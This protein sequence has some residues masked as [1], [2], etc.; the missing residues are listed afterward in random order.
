MFMLWATL[1]TNTDGRCAQALPETSGDLENRP[2]PPS[3]EPR[4]RIRL[5]SEPLDATLIFGQE[6]QQLLCFD[7]KDSRVYLRSGPLRVRHAEDG[8][9][10][11][12]GEMRSNSL[13]GTGVLSI[14]TLVD[15][16]SVIRFQG[17]SL[18][19]FVDLVPFTSSNSSAKSA[20]VDVI[21][22]VFLE[23]YLPGVLDVE[24]YGHWPL[25]TFQAQAVAARSY[26]LAEAAFWK[27]RRHFD[28][29]AGPESQ[30]WS[31]NGGSSKAR[32]AVQETFGMVLLHQG[33]IVPAYYSAACGGFPASADNA[34]SSR[35]SHRIGPLVP[36]VGRPSGCCDDSAVFKWTA[37]FDRGDLDRALNEWQR[38]KGGDLGT[39]R[40]LP[41]RFNRLTVLERSPTGRSLVYGLSSGGEKTLSIDAESFR[42]LLSKLTQI[43]GLD[44]TP[45]RSSMFTGRFSG[46]RFVVEGLG[47]GHGCG[48]CQYGANAMGESG[49]TWRQILERFYPGSEVGPIWKSDDALDIERLPSQQ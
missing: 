38:S 30:G 1:S 10:L 36:L 2:L 33:R 35:A 9:F 24:L 44:P 17:R 27:N 16:L 37:K 49:F 39:A 42:R 32:E 19:G 18:P 14:R 8:W 48:L 6:G 34:I 5:Q 41:E 40:N 23:R 3:S 28:L 47:W 12:D 13:T 25:E 22:S 45:L 26:A 46:K 11:V 7:E 31:G 20:R 43:E 29:V 4:V 21:V 15:D